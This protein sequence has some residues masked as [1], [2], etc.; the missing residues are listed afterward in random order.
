MPL[1]AREGLKRLAAARPDMAVVDFVKEPIALVAGAARIV[2]MGGYNTICEVLSLRRPALIV[3]RCRPRAEQILRA[4]RL[5]ALGLIDMIPPERL[6]AGSLGA[7]LAAPRQAA[8]PVQGVLDLGG[9]GRV[10]DMAAAILTPA[11]GR[12]RMAA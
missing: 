5:A 10:R 3:P 1:A 8:R 11:D 6:G 4:E 12:T 7:W 2:A 9:L